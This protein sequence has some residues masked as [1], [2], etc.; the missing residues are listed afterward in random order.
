[1]PAIHAMSSAGREGGEACPS[2]L[3]QL[4]GTYFTTRYQRYQT[5]CIVLNVF[6]K[7]S[8]PLAAPVHPRRLSGENQVSQAM[9]L[10]RDSP[11]HRGEQPGG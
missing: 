11:M 6:V 10:A 5:G 1:M 2:G 3:Q 7:H 8:P 9:L 4:G